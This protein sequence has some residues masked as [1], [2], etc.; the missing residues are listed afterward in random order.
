MATQAIDPERFKDLTWRR[1]QL[2][3]LLADGRNEAWAAKEM[4]I[5]RSTVRSH[6]EALKRILECSSDEELSR[7]W[8]SGRG[9]WYAWMGT[10]AGIAAS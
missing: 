2:L 3:G 9:E 6:A 5:A 10:I 1:V 8:R 4:C 7:R